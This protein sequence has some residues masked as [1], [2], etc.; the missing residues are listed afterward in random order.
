MLTRQDVLEHM[1]NNRCG[2]G[3]IMSTGE[4]RCEVVGDRLLWLHIGSQ[5]WGLMIF[6]PDDTGKAGTGK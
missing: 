6:T 4:V 2:F 1:A 5:T 3:R